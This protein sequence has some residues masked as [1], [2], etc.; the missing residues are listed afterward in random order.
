MHLSLS[1]CV[2]VY[3][4]AGRNFWP[5]QKF[6]LQARISA[7]NSGLEK[8]SRKF[9]PGIPGQNSKLKFSGQNSKPK[10]SGQNSKLK[11][12][13]ELFLSA[14]LRLYYL[15]RDVRVRT[16]SEDGRSLRQPWRLEDL[17]SEICSFPIWKP[18]YLRGI[19]WHSSLSIVFYMLGS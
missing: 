12:Q 17:R 10:C 13:L 1:L 15:P 11:F 6:C 19:D 5:G 2:R 8:I 16:I 3:S 7:W 4:S 18:A 14:Y 9:R